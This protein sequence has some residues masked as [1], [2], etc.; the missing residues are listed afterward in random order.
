MATD[1]NTKTWSTLLEAMAALS[2]E[3]TPVQILRAMA[4]GYIPSP[5]Y[6]EHLGLRLSETEPGTATMAWEPG[7]AVCAPTGNVHGG[8]VAMVFDETCCLAGAS[9]GDRIYPMITLNL[10]ID[11]LKPMWS[12]R[13][14]KVD[15]EVAH[16][17][18]RRMV[19]NSSIRDSEDVLLAQ[20][21]AALT[22]NLAFADQARKDD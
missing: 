11:Y 22:P 5:T 8:Y 2:N 9:H 3:Q 20:A 17:S 14:Y 16:G 13:S 18:K 4:K 10:N 19:V 15:G 7:Q 21:T 6:Y 12:G 1:D